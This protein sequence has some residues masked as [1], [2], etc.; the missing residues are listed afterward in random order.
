M[1]IYKYICMDICFCALYFYTFV[2]SIYTVTQSMFWCTG[3]LVRLKE[4]CKQL[5]TWSQIVASQWLFWANGNQNPCATHTQINQSINQSINK[6][7]NKQTNKQA[8]VWVHLRIR[9]SPKFHMALK[10]QRLNVDSRFHQAKIHP[11]AFPSSSSIPIY[12]N[13]SSQAS[14]YIPQGSTPDEPNI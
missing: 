1:C 12:L 3:H 4:T 2:L 8:R 5:H 9:D 7:L 11:F 6:Q 13:A 10:F 14:Q